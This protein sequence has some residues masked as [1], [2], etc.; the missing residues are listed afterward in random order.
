MM[1]PNVRD[2]I[3]GATLTIMI[4]TLMAAG[5]AN[6]S[7]YAECEDGRNRSDHGRDVCD[8]RTGIPQEL[9]QMEPKPDGRQR[10]A[11]VLSGGITGTEYRQ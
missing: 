10:T 7:L 11:H 3:S 2:A 1:R 5:G 6:R 4:D 8:D 9:R